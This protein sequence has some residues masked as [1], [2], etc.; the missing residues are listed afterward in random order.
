MVGGDVRL[1]L[2]CANCV[3]ACGRGHSVSHSASAAV[4][5]MAG[6]R[7]TPAEKPIEVIFYYYF[8][9]LLN[10]IK[11]LNLRLCAFADHSTF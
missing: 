10:S 9:T 11:K 7:R 6:L 5:L 2:V 1:D 8:I 4:W 3:L